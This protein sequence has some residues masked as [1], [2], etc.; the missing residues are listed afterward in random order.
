MSQLF[1]V[2]GLERLI[3]TQSLTSINL[4]VNM[5]TSIE[6]VFGFCESLRHLDLS[7]NHI[8]RIENLYNCRQLEYLSLSKNL[9]EEIENLENL[10]GL[11]HLVR[12][13]SLIVG[14]IDE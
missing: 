14:L 13:L 11:T 1:S 6:P 7:I 5:L 8:K 12:L 9:I 4:S 3:K 10:Q 2:T